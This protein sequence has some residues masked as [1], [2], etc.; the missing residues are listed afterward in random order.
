MKNI[1]SDVTPTPEINNRQA[2]ED[3]RNAEMPKCLCAHTHT[4]CALCA[5]LQEQGSS[6]ILG[7]TSGAEQRKAGSPVPLATPHQ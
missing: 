1:L 2:F 5:V 3:L 7:K 6:L 4:T